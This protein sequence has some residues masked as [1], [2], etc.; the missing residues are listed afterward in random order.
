[1]RC[2]TTIN[3]AC[4]TSLLQGC[5]ASHFVLTDESA[6]ASLMATNHVASLQHHNPTPLR[7]SVEYAEADA[8]CLYLGE[9]HPTH[10]V[11]IGSFRVTSDGRVWANSDP[12]LLE[13]RW[14]L[15]Q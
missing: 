11:R 12:T 1:M 6:I 13:N 9:D 10:T 2:A 15:I 3:L 7:C 14:S 8:I 5:G 4:L